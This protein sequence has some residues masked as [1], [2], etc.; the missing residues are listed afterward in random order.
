MLESQDNNYGLNSNQSAFMP[1][2][3]DNH[4]QI[5]K[6]FSTITF[7]ECVEQRVNVLM[8]MHAQNTEQ[9]HCELPNGFFTIKFLKCV[10]QREKLP[11]LMHARI[12]RRGTS[13]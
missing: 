10:E 13:E 7:F 2:L 6:T 11:L 3:Q 8:L 12:T 4:E 1:E 5:I 9:S